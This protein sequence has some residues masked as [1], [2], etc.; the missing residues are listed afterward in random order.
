MPTITLNRA[1]FEK[2]VGK[3]LT[4]DELKERISMLGTDLEGIYTKEIVIEIFPNRPDLLSEQGFARA[5]ASFI[6][7]KPGLRK[8]AVKKSNA[9]TKIE[10]ALKTW[11]YAVTCIVKGL[12]LDDERIREIIQLQEKLGI[13]LLRNRKKGG[14]GVYP[15][16]KIALP[17]TFTTR[18]AEDIKFHPLEYPDIITGRQILEKHPTGRKYA[19]IL[20]DEKEFPLFIDA[21]GIIM[22]MPPIINSH[23]VGRITETTK[24]VFIEL[25][26]PE[27]HTLVVALNIFV[28]TLADM[29]GTI[30]S[31]DVEYP[32]P[33]DV[34]P[35][36]DIKPTKDVK[37]TNKPKVK[38]SSTTL[39]FP[40]LTPQKMKVDLGY[41]NRILGL[42]LSEEDLQKCLLKMGYNYNNKSAIIPAYR[43]D[44]MHQIDLVEDI[45]IAYGYE[46]IGEEVPRV[47]TVAE[48]APLYSF[49][50]KLTE[51]LA[52]AGMQ[53]TKNYHIYST[54]ELQSKMNSTLQCIPLKNA[55]ADCDHIR[56]SLLPGLLRVLAQNQH[57]DYPQMLF[58][59]G[60]IA[61]PDSS[62]EHAVREQHVLG[63]TLCHEKADFT[64]IRQIIDM[65]TRLLGL[66]PELAE[67]QHNS[68]IH[69]RC[70]QL[71]IGKTSG[72]APLATFG[73]LHPKVL[74]AW[75]LP[76]PVAAAEIDIDALFK[77]VQEKQAE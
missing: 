70:A 50:T 7:A 74:T 75:N 16:D 63:I 33:A 14:L 27:L 1:V 23:D 21:K 10:R 28:T 55:P 45:A 66:Q 34:K 52:G 40:D 25:T 44:I 20:N 49:I 69:G 65:L 72:N 48:E 29:G 60:V 71:S 58:E 56:N 59:S 22:S 11:P 24:D 57:H 46:N 62:A 73:E 31:M 42:S 19:H 38:H 15:L 5:F 77:A 53:E 61:L 39:T 68:F 36:K 76:M 64:S 35:T 13:T 9:S 47:A 4:E 6:G 41:I 67:A 8:Y 32:H 51:L 30:Y 26:G 43:A 12:A 18:K 3:K 37:P 17:V 2:L 54:D